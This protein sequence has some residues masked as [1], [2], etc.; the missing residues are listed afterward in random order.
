MEGASS[1]R[2]WLIGTEQRHIALATFDGLPA[3]ASKL[4]TVARRPKHDPDLSAPCDFQ[5]LLLIRRVPFPSEAD[6]DHPRETT[7]GSGPLQCLVRVCVRPSNK[8][9]KIV[10]RYGFLR[11]KVRTISSLSPLL[12]TAR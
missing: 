1:S 4:G 5:R 3:S 11:E 6:A 2:C 10:R 7:R 12:A 8:F 9:L